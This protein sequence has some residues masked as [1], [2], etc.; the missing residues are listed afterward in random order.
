M[1]KC[2]YKEDWQRRAQKCFLLC[3]GLTPH[4]HPE[5]SAPIYSARPGL[6]AQAQSCHK[7]AQHRLPVGRTE[8]LLECVKARTVPALPAAPALCPDPL[9]HTLPAPIRPSPHRAEAETG[10]SSDP[11]AGHA[12]C[13]LL[14]PLAGQVAKEAKTLPD[15]FSPSAVC[16]QQK[17]PESPP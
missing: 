6:H 7:Q 14:G 11:S 16:L 17:D 9:L 5:D 12:H 3:P 13:I 8:K 1:A 15:N 2:N 10:S 4:L